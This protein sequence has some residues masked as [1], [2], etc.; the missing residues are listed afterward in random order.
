MRASSP[1]AAKGISFKKIK[2]EIK[3]IISFEKGLK[4]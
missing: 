1:S 4:I 3:N 2:E